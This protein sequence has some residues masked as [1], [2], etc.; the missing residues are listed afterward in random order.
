MAVD[1]VEGVAEA[2]GGEA[3]GAMRLPRLRR[4]LLS[5]RRSILETIPGSSS[6]S[7]AEDLVAA[8]CYRPRSRARWNRTRPR[9]W[10]CA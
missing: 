10:S 7:C 4:R 9:C 3:A 5:S 6:S 1:E 2:L 8:S